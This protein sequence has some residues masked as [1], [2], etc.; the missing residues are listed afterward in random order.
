MIARY[1][2]ARREWQHLVNDVEKM[3]GYLHRQIDHQIDNPHGGSQSARS[4]RK[5]GQT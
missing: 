2:T 3:V 4:A 5:G 1:D